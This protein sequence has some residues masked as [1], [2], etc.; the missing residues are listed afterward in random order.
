M[1]SRAWC[2][3]ENQGGERLSYPCVGSLGKLQK[4][5]LSPRVTYGV[6]PESHQVRD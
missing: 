4:V 2:K 1:S 3:E 6:S 5:L